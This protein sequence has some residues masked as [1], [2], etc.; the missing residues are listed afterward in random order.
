M[1]ANNYSPDPYNTASVPTDRF[2]N[3]DSDILHN[4]T[5]PS[6][7]LPSSDSKTWRAE[8]AVVEVVVVIVVGEVVGV[9]GMC[10]LI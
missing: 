5:D 3:L 1:G 8:A 4:S 7:S 6:L 10:R 9:G 2:P